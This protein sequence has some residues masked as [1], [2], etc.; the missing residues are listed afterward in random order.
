MGLTRL[1]SKMIELP[2][3]LENIIAD[4]VST[5]IINGNTAIF[6]NLSA[7]NVAFGTT[8][9]NVETVTTS[10][11]VFTNSDNTKAYHFNT[12]NNDI[13]AVFPS[14]LNTGF[15]IT[16]LNTSTGFI[17]LSSTDLIQ[18]TGQFNNTPFTGMFIYK[19]SDGLFYGVGVFE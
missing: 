18:A 2:A 5:N 15:N 7:N 13:S 6:Q 17:Y 9:Y 1:N 11:K 10:T 4:N 12:L 19:A 16:I 14:S 3:E 8:N